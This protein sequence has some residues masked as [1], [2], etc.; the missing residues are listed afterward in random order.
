MRG[1]SRR[2]IDQQNSFKK[3]G[4]CKL[5]AKLGL[6]QPLGDYQLPE[7]RLDKILQMEFPH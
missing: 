2:L 6:E 5:I 7:L 4:S 3:D 1:Y